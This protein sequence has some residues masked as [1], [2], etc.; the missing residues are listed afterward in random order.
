M[1][2]NVCHGVVKNFTIQTCDQCLTGT[3]KTYAYFF[4]L[5][6]F[7]IQLSCTRILFL[8]IAYVHKMMTYAEL[9]AYKLLQEKE[10]IHPWPNYIP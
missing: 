7:N 8:F 2:F 3:N 5:S 6:S 4:L 1:H 10:S 9:R